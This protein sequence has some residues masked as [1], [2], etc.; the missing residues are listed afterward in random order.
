MAALNLSERLGLEFSLEKIVCNETYLP[1]D[2]IETGETIKKLM[3]A[4]P[5]PCPMRVTFDGSPPNSLMLS[6][7][8]CNAAI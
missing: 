7:I 2:A 8:H 5:V 1:S 6:L 4:A 3:Q